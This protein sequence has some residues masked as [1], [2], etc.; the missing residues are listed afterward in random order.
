MTT[1]VLVPGAWHGSWAWDRV[2]PLLHEAGVHTIT[3]ELSWED[4]AGLH[5][6]VQQLVDALD[7]AGDDL[8][9]VGHSYGA[10]VVREAAD[11]RPQ[12]VRHII[13]VD[14][15]AGPDGAG[16]FTLAPA[17][18]VDALQGMANGDYIPAPPP[19]AFGVTDPDDAEWLS[20]RLVP[21]PLRTFSEVSR[22]T[23]AVDQIPG[24]AIYCRPQTYPFEQLAKDLGYRTIPIDAPHNVV[25]THPH[26]LSALLLDAHHRATTS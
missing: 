23:G 21:Q 2:V 17:P 20:Q 25:L 8:V 1:F 10:L 15:W 5:D 12:L 26:E 13:L 4:G 24:T 3:P 11:Q 7:A 16:M 6:H 14:G 9:L 18:F 19:A 22:L